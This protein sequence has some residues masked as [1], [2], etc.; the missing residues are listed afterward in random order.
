MSTPF[1]GLNPDDVLGVVLENLRTQVAL[2]LRTFDE[3]AAHEVEDYVIDG[4]EHYV[5][6]PE[7][8]PEADKEQ[9]RAW[10]LS[11]LDAEFAAH[12][13]AQEDSEGPVEAERLTAAFTELNGAGIVARENFECCNTCARSAMGGEIEE[14]NG[15]RAAEGLPPVHGFVFYHAQDADRLQ[16]YLGFDAVGA[17]SAEAKG[18]V[19]REIVESLR[20][21]GLEPEWNGDPEMKILGPSLVRRRTGR[22]AEHP[23]R[24]A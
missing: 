12:L 1:Y 13:R 3:I 19:G 10:L 11:V 9:H 22:L 5:H 2:G 14:E 16:P 21:H 17:E 8:L 15:T 4:L 7:L 20:R 24:R 6:E 23:G 18:A